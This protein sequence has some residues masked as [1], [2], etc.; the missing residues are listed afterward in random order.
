MA[1]YDDSA[2]VAKNIVKYKMS[3]IDMLEKTKNEMVA[4]G[5]DT[6]KIDAEIEEIRKEMDKLNEALEKGNK[7][8]IDMALENERGSVE[9][10]ENCLPVDDFAVHF[11]G[12]DIDGKYVKSFSWDENSDEKTLYISLYDYI[13]ENSDG[14]VIKL[15]KTLSEK[16]GQNIGDILFTYPTIPLDDRS[17]VFRFT[18]CKLKYYYM[19]GFR[20]D[21]DTP[22][23]HE[24]NIE[25]TFEN[26]E[27]AD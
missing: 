10:S 7:K 27:C 25:V 19:G 23:C 16:N 26:T 1:R 14:N 17:Y 18:A 24:V 13:Y 21:T 3:T 15:M 6:E 20:K 5:R 2:S 12:I 9:L 8:K 11:D 22:T 4:K